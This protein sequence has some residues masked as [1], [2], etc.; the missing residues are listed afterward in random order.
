VSTLGN[1]LNGKT[2]AGDELLKKIAL[3][4]SVPP[5]DIPRRLPP[6]DARGESEDAVGELLEVD[7]SEPG[8]ARGNPAGVEPFEWMARKLDDATIKSLITQAMN[9]R[10]LDIA[11]SLLEILE[12]RK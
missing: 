5:D 2:D 6:K 3:F 11:R 12:G 1:Y 7:S 10:R 9:D 4:L 8:P